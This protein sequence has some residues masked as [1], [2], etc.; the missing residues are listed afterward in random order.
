MAKK[1]GFPP[2]LDQFDEQAGGVVDRAKGGFSVYGDVLFR[3]D[4]IAFHTVP[5]RNPGY[6]Q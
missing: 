4:S 5:D 6:S 2:W 3:I 1:A